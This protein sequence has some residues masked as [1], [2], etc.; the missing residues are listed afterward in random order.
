MR[1]GGSFE[2]KSPPGRLVNSRGALTG[3]LPQGDDQ[4]Q[5]AFYFL[6]MVW[7][8]QVL[9]IPVPERHSVGAEGELNESSYEKQSAAKCR[10]YVSG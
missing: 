5:G 9:I 1:T 2:R 8:I 6:N 10:N 3:N 7:K 4:R